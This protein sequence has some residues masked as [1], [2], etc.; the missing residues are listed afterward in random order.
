MQ[1]SPVVLWRKASSLERTNTGV[2]AVQCIRVTMP[3]MNDTKALTCII[4][5]CVC[6]CVCGL[7]L[8][9]EQKKQ[10]MLVRRWCFVKI[11]K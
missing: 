2:D 4:F 10:H 6:V 9:Q 5:G 3:P 7:A 8:S 1:Q 11:N